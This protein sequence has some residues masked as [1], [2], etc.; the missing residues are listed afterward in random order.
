MGESADGGNSSSVCSELKTCTNTVT[1]VPAC[2]QVRLGYH[3]AKTI[4]G[5]SNDGLGEVGSEVTC[6]QACSTPHN[7]F[8]VVFSSHSP[9]CS[10]VQTGKW[11]N[12][13]RWNTNTRPTE[14]TV[15][16]RQ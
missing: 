8:R 3:I 15:D 11:T 12:D 4:E 2:G 14:Y 6:K 13:C 16:T 5:C 7:I 1:T 10:R 9:N